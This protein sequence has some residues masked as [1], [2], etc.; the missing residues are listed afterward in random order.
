[1]D[2]TG[3][4]NSLD[5]NTNMKQITTL[6]PEYPSEQPDLQGSQLAHDRIETSSPLINPNNTMPP[7]EQHEEHIDVQALTIDHNEKTSTEVHGDHVGESKES[8][9]IKTVR[10]DFSS[11]NS[12]PAGN[13]AEKKKIP[14][15]SFSVA[16]TSHEVSTNAAQS[17]VLRIP[18]KKGLKV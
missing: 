10:N 14:L 8:G 13:T 7:T 5:L 4:D 15:N 1:M 12:E 11:S 18:K 6:P 3:S 16:D 9:N 2:I 17:C